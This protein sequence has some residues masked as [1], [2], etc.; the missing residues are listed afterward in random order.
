MQE[1]RY[2]SS[3]FRNQ[4]KI[5]LHIKTWT[6]QLAN[7][8][9]QLILRPSQLCQ[10]SLKT[11]P[12]ENYSLAIGGSHRSGGDGVVDGVARV[13]GDRGDRAVH[14]VVHLV[15]GDGQACDNF[16]EKSTKKKTR[17]ALQKISP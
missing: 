15:L 11:F 1:I 6:I 9:V 7:I 17:N 4:F 16:N 12:I 2:R 10:S 14:V 5:K 13:A 8:E 3:Q